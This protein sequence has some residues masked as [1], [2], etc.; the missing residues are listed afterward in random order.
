[1]N[2][3][4]HNVR[5]VLRNINWLIEPHDSHVELM[6]IKGKKVIIRSTGACATCESD[7]IRVAF[8]ERLPDIQLIIKE[9]RPHE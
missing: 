5:S 6:Q 8:R 4:E 2:E 3:L 9:D 1:M 7:C